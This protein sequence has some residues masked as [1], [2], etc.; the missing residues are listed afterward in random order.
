MSRYSH[1]FL[2]G[3]PPVDL[4]AV[5]RVKKRGTSLCTRWTGSCTSGPVKSSVLDQKSCSG[6]N[7]RNF[8][9]N[10]RSCRRSQSQDQ[11]SPVLQRMHPK[12]IAWSRTLRG[13]VCCLFCVC[14]FFRCYNMDSVSSAPYG[15]SLG[16]PSQVPA[17]ACRD[18][19]NIG[20]KEQKPGGTPL[21]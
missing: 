17:V 20:L 13:Q 16:E 1:T 15:V 8:T 19:A 14:C 12:I 9:L 11:K 7:R 10:P 4:P 2:I 6:R 5:L 3:L 21:S 18:H